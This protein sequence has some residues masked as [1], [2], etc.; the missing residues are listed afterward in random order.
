MRNWLHWCKRTLLSESQMQNNIRVQ[1]NRRQ[2]QFWRLIVLEVVL[3]K[4]S[5]HI[6][7]RLFFQIFVRWVNKSFSKW[8]SALLGHCLR[9]LSL[10]LGDL[11]FFCVRRTLVH[12]K[13]C[14]SGN[15]KPSS[16]L[17]VRNCTY[18]FGFAMQYFWRTKTDT[19][20]QQ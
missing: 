4:F 1:M 15:P 3:Q 14:L 10:F 18:N 12:S 7:L 19:E 17:T 13:A 6:E 2:L 5:S 9:C 16:S 20:W 8:L 11:K